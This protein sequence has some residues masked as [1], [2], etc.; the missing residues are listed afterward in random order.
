MPGLGDY[1]SGG[2]EDWQRLMLAGGQLP[3]SP[4]FEPPPQSTGEEYAGLGGDPSHAARWLANAATALAT[5]PQRAIEGAGAYQ[6]GVRREDVTDIPATGFGSQPADV[7][8]GPAAETALLTMFP[9]AGTGPEAGFALTAGRA[10]RGAYTQPR[11][12]EDFVPPPMGHN[13]PPEPMVPEPQPAAAAPAPAPTATPVAE[14][15]A[16]EAVLPKEKTWAQ[17]LPPAQP[18]KQST[19]IP[20]IRGMSVADAIAIAR[21]QPHLIKSGERG[22]GLYVG[23]PRDIQT[24]RQLNQTRTAFD[25]YLG[26]DPRGGDWYDRYRA[27]MN[28][29]TGGD[30]VQNRWMSAQEGQWSAGVDP[31]T[32][33]HFALKENNAALAGMPVKAGRPAPHEAHLAAIAAKDPS[34]YQAGEKTGEY[35]AKVNPDQPLPPGA[36]GVNDFRHARNFRYT[37]PSGAPQREALGPAGHNFLDMETALAVDR[38]NRMALGGR[39][40]WT[41]EKLQAAP[42]VRQKALDLMARN[43][44]L[45]YEEAFARANRTIA[46]YFDR[47]TAFATHEAQP[48]ADTGHM[49]GSIAAPAE[50]RTAF[51]QDPRSTWATAPGGRD[52]IY[53]GMGIPGTGVNMRVRPTQPM[54]GLYINPDGTLETNLGEVARPLVTFDTAKDPFK[55]TTKHDQAL[56]NAGEAVRAYVDAQNA[57]AWH[58]TWAGGPNKQSTSLRFPREGPAAPEELLA[59]RKALEPHGLT[60]IVD[61]GKGITATRFYGGQPEP[62]LAFD[63]AL[64]K[65]D[66]SQFGEPSRVRVGEGD[67]GYIDY[68]D[69]WQKG[70]GSGAATRRM[71]DYVNKTPEIRTALNDNPYLGERALA[72]VARDENWTAKWGATRED[73]QNARRIIGDGPGWVDRMEEALKKGAILPA[74]AAAILGADALVRQEGG[75]NAAL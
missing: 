68:V 26:A 74:A 32:E 8:V 70:P 64:R 53:S 36:T 25:K 47:H 7:A 9:A 3:Q 72:R 5:L 45:T 35:A 22:E 30:P 57:G 65:G 17:G 43:P 67:S 6:P 59:L 46:D 69:A 38:A 21:T 13:M 54:Q 42:W 4:G 33:V 16:T 63:R 37:D 61:V 24:K 62:N 40:D 19:D 58:K 12:P 66:F 56:L 51:A 60:D 75:S 15:L 2:L 49:L 28:E 41:G 50:E 1:L 52:A 48:G 27:G 55:V 23:G 44:A 14:Q 73:I 39:T 10:R 11:P 31:G 29:V 18:A 20:N 71:L 34:L